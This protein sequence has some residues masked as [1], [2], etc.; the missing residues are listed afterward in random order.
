[1]KVSRIAVTDFRA[2]YEV[3]LDVSTLVCVLGENNAGKSSLLQAFMRFCDGRAVP[4]T[5]FYDPSHEMRVAVDLTGV[6]DEDLAVLREEEHRQ[7]ICELLVGKTLKLVRVYMPGE[8]AQLR[9]VR[10]LP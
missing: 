10:H 1:M 6:T 9:C 7:R 3:S 5:D 8:R 4:E 2:L